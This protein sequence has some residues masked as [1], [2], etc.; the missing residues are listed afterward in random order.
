M[1]NKGQLLL[2]G[3]SKKSDATRLV[4]NNP[5]PVLLGLTKVFWSRLVLLTTCLLKMSDY[6]IKY[7]NS[8]LRS[9]I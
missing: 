6:I 4:E 1:K 3:V 8:I 7:N 2:Y 5:K 9:R